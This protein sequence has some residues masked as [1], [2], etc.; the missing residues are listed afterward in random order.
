MPINAHTLSL[1]LCHFHCVFRTEEIKAGCCQAGVWR[2]AAAALCFGIMRPQLLVSVAVESQWIDALAVIKSSLGSRS[3]LPTVSYRSPRIPYHVKI[4][5][6]ENARSFPKPNV[7]NC[8]PHTTAASNKLG[9]NSGK[10][11]PGRALAIAH[12][13]AALSSQRN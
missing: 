2:G 8:P 5:Q 7:H 10:A 9:F 12:H 6:E 11:G 3:Y 1:V 13:L 4:Q